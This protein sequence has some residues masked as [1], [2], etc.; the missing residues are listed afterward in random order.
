MS[1]AVISHAR[2]FTLVIKRK[3][4]CLFPEGRKVPDCQSLRAPALHRPAIPPQLRRD[5]SFK[6]G[7]DC[8]GSEGG[9]QLAQAGRKRA[10]AAQISWVKAPSDPWPR[11][12]R[13]TGA[14][15]ADIP[16]RFAHLLQQVRAPARG[17]MVLHVGQEHRFHFGFIVS[18][19]VC[20]RWE[21]RQSSVVASS[22]VSCR[23]SAVGLCLEDL[24]A[25]G[26]SGRD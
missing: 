5:I 21:N 23:V 6:T 11:D 19:C 4:L 26:G 16:C 17:L 7:S 10:I 3:A 1:S 20:L 12:G 14:R 22:V 9:N 15:S 13:K 18:P 2:W 8:R 24:I 25:T